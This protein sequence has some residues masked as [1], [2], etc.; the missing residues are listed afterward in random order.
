V[1]SG[2]SLSPIASSLSPAPGSL[3]SIES[4]VGSDGQHKQKE[5]CLGRTSELTFPL[6]EGRRRAVDQLAE[7]RDESIG[8]FALGH[9]FGPNLG[10]FRG[11]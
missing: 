2:C 3:L 11:R 4:L 5:A 9:R 10:G 1:V 6:V 8:S 7:L